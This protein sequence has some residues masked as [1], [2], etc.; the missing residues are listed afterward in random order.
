VALEA[1]GVKYAIRVLATG[2]LRRDITGLLTRP[3]GRPSHKLVVWYKG[4]LYQAASWKTARR[5]LGAIMRR[6]SALPLPAGEPKLWYPKNR[7]DRRPRTETC[8][9]NRLHERQIAFLR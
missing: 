1:R 5:P 8:L 9:K 7:S 4:F 3:A 6:I 2:S